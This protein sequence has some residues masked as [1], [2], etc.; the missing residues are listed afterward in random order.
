MA[1]TAG[2]SLSLFIWVLIIGVGVLYG[3]WGGHIARNCGL[4]YWIGFIVGLLGGLIGILVL[5]LVGR[6]RIKKNKPVPERGQPEAGHIR[7]R[8][9]LKVCDRCGKLV[10]SGA[11]FCQYCGAVFTS[12]AS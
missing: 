10:E 5:W 12:A 4:D 11:T 7:Q 9:A 6:D 3:F 1:D 8:Q 2:S